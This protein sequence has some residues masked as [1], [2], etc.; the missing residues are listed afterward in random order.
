MLG[1]SAAGAVQILHYYGSGTTLRDE[2]VGGLQQLCGMERC[3][4]SHDL[5][6]SQQ[7]TMQVSLM[8]VRLAKLRQL[9]SALNV[10][11]R[12]LEIVALSNGPIHER[13]TV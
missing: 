2:F 7:L 1:V 9:E 4:L 5:M 13:L 11:S 8:M 12:S 10:M 6:S 3:S